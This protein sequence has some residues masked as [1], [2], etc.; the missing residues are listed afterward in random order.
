[1]TTRAD[2]TADLLTPEA[3]RERCNMIF[4]LAVAGRTAHFD[5]D[6]TRLDTAATLVVSEM[7]RNYP[8]GDVPLHSRWRHF[9]FGGSDFWSQTLA[10]H[11]PM[12]TDALARARIDL[13]V[14]S[15]LLDAGAGSDWRFYDPT[16]GLIVGRSEGLALASLRMF[17]AGLL[18]NDPA[19]DPLRVDQLAL[20][21][22]TTEALARAFQVTPQNALLGVDQRTSLLNNVGRTMGHA[23]HVFARDDAVRPGHLFDYLKSRAGAA[24]VVPARLILIT[25]LQHLGAAWP[26]ARRV[27][28]TAIADASDFP[29]LKEVGADDGIVPFH[30]LSQ[31]LSYSLI[32]PLQE[33][34]IEVTDLDGLTGLA[35]YRN[36]GLL[37]DTGVL[38][39]KD[40][41]ARQRRYGASDELIVEWRALTIALLDRVADRVRSM[42]GTDATSLPLGAVLQGGTWSAGRRLAAEL[43]TGGAPPLTIATDGTLF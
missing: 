21:T 10:R 13:A 15:V 27:G 32:E 40:S 41:E 5:V 24:G 16:S 34:G 43:R 23:S 11:A 31:W 19:R 29:A 36:G 39:F 17:E 20:E 42:T 4:D 38:G 7:R 1:M 35:E 37:I 25:L 26:G 22:L 8:D 9:E 6:L 2:A 18:S 3:V 12:A 30:K 33:A 28:D 14:I